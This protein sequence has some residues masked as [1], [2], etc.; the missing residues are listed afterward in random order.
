MNPTERPRLSTRRRTE[1]QPD[2]N[3]RKNRLDFILDTESFLL[4]VIRHSCTSLRNRM[5][6]PN[7]RPAGNA[8][9]PLRRRYH[10]IGWGIHRM[11]EALKRRTGKRGEGEESET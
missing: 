6:I 1:R 7:N 11:S 9:Q 8:S 10:R 2:G 5:I 3:I 4:E